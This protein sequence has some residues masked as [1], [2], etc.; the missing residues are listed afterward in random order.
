MRG[1]MKTLK[2]FTKLGNRA[3]AAGLSLALCLA[4]AG[5]TPAQAQNRIDEPR[6]DPI[7]GQ[8]VPQDRDMPLITNDDEFDDYDQ[9]WSPLNGL[10]G[11]LTFLTPDTTDLSLGLG[12][13]YKPDYFGSDDYQLGVDPQVYVKFRNFVFLDDDGADFALFGF[14]G[15]SFGPSLRIAGS[16]NEDENEALEG[17]GDVGTTFEFGGFAATTF[18]N[19]YSVRFK[20]RRG[21]SSGHRGL[22]VD[23]Y[24]TAVLFRSKPFSA[25][26]SAQTSW[27]GDNYADTYFSIDPVQA[28]NSGLPQFEAGRGFRDVGAS[29]NG[30]FNVRKRWS[31]NPYVSYRYALGDVAASPIVSQEGDRNQ[32]RAGFHLMR[33]FEFK[34]F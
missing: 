10:V 18:L 19:R 9:G 29:L 25:S 2:N 1:V 22:I 8:K 24:S 5:L 6:L 16:R 13:E 27:I 17:L 26:I 4:G 20:I 11:V 32:F 34:M 31:L 30:Y 14:S 23:A 15:F 3:K 7:F 33:E 21:I 12:P 28:L